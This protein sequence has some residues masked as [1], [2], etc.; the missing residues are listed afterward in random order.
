MNCSFRFLSYGPTHLSVLARAQ[1]WILDAQGVSALNSPPVGG[2][3]S[4]GFSVSLCKAPICVLCWSPKWHYRNSF[5][6]CDFW[7]SVRGPCDRSPLSWAV[8]LLHWSHLLSD[9]LMGAINELNLSNHALNE[10]CPPLPTTHSS[11]H[12]RAP[13]SE[14]PRLYKL[15]GSHTSRGVFRVF[16]GVLS[17]ASLTQPCPLTTLVWGGWEGQSCSVGRGERLWPLSPNFPVPT[18]GTRLALLVL[19][20]A[21][22]I[23]CSPVLSCRMLGDPSSAAGGVGGDPLYPTHCWEAAGPFWQMLCSTHG[24]QFQCWGSTA[25]LS[26]LSLPWTDLALSP[27]WCLTD[28][29]FT[30]PPIS[31]AF[32]LVGIIC[33]FKGSFPCSFRNILARLVHMDF[34]GLKCF[35]VLQLL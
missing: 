1:N 6:C 7:C 27:F 32:L 30:S 29:A 3:S 22:P 11:L 13:L 9:A 4:D 33:V 28:L 2:N 5:V 18:P 26:D 21:S 24:W 16:A 20:R 23:Q 12:P 31:T 8:L 10:P 35:V 34:V 19:S 14:S 15:M 17:S 25:S